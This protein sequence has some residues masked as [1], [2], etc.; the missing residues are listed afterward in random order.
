[1][2]QTLE[3][4]RLVLRDVTMADPAGYHRNFVDYAVISELTRLVPWPYP[5]D[6][7]PARR[8]GRTAGSGRCI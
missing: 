8:R 3:T 5:D 2:I 6:G 4:A 7:V 1:M